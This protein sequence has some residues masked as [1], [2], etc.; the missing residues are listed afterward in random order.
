MPLGSRLKK[1]GKL[2]PFLPRPSRKRRRGGEGK[3]SRKVKA[4]NKEPGKSFLSG[5]RRRREGRDAEPK[6]KE[7]K[8]Q[9]CGA[10]GERI[11]L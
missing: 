2:L 6:R 4:S 11:H 8:Q 5:R 1:G 7:K 3:P 9:F 10:W